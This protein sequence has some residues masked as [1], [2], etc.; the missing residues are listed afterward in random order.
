MERMFD[1]DSFQDEIVSPA[2]AQ[3]C[4]SYLARNETKFRK[5][6]STEGLSYEAIEEEVRQVWLNLLKSCN[7]VGYRDA[8]VEV[9]SAQYG[10]GV[11]VAIPKST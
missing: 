10:R 6:L 5:E 11:N 8:T 9:K 1:K 3:A 7:R 4:V 2:E